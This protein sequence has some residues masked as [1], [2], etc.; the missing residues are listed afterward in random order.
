MINVTLSRRFVMEGSSGLCLL[1]RRFRRLRLPALP[2]VNQILGAYM[3]RYTIG[4]F[5]DT[6]GVVTSV[7]VYGIRPEV[8][9]TLEDHLVGDSDEW[10]DTQRRWGR[11]CPTRL[12][13]LLPKRN[14]S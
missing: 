4:V 10:R 8:I 14:R 11:F 13:R 9:V 7:E 2:S 3:S 5:P 1:G 6:T 12:G